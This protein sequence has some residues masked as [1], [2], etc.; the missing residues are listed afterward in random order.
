VP[1]ITDFIGRKKGDEG[2]TRASSE[3]KKPAN[4]VEKL[5]LVEE[6]TIGA[7]RRYLFRYA[8]TGIYLNVSGRSKGEALE[9]ALEIV[10]KLYGEN[11][12]SDLER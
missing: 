10:K 2:T 12:G 7:T 3:A 6:K 8:P 11:P 9:R 4:E 5:I 1:S